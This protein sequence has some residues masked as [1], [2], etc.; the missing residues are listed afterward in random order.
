MEWT[1]SFEALR[2]ATKND[3]QYCGVIFDALAAHIAPKIELPGTKI[4]IRPSP[5]EK[6]IHIHIKPKF[7]VDETWADL[8]VFQ[9]PG[10]SVEWGA[11]AFVRGDYR[12]KHTSAGDN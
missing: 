12:L 11:L 8:E 7:D 3:C 5:T 2:D 10:T 1:A 4:A 9:N 6:L